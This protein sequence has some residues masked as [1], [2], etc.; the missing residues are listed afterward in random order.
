[1]SMSEA[2]EQSCIWVYRDNYPIARTGS[3][4][5]ANNIAIKQVESYPDSSITI[6]KQTLVK[7]ELRTY[8]PFPK[9]GREFQ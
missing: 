2:T 6:E 5:E 8:R 1:M 7:Q 9:K 3:F 4:D